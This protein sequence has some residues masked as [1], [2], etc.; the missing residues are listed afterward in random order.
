MATEDI[1]EDQDG[2]DQDSQQMEEE[3]QDY[4]MED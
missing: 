4:Q 2:G 1:P 3:D